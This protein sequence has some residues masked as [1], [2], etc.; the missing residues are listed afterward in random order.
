[1][2]I[3]RNVI[4]TSFSICFLQPVQAVT[5]FSHK[6]LLTIS[7]IVA[8]S[9]VYLERYVALTDVICTKTTQIKVPRP[10]VYLMGNRNDFYVT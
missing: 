7:L 3:K 1:M 10:V 8:I 9:V 2:A 5:T 4:K 6:N